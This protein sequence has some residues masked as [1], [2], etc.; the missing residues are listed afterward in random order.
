MIEHIFQPA[1]VRKA[2]PPPQAVFRMG[3]N[4]RMAGAMPVWTKDTTPREEIART[5]GDATRPHSMHDAT[6]QALAYRATVPH[7]PDGDKPF[8]FGD[9]LDM[10]NPLHHIPVVGH[11]YRHITGDEIR[12]VSRIIGGTLFGG[13]IGAA[14]GLA[15]VIVE[16]ETGRDIPETMMAMVRPPSPQTA[17]PVIE[18]EPQTRLAQT[19][20]T[21]ELP[22]SMLSFVDLSREEIIWNGPRVGV[23]ATA[24]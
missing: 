19:T 7:A 22:G 17:P 21:A 2:A 11:I 4:E 14:S 13:P 5:L 18:E 23:Q 9:L 10:V 16:H 24:G 12:P 15:N 6:G 1:P 20:T 8:G 3:G